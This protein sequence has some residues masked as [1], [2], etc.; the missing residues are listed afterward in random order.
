MDTDDSRVPY[1]FTIQMWRDG[2][3]KEV[4]VER[5]EL[6]ARESLGVV[7]YSGLYNKRFL[8]IRVLNRDG[9]KKRAIN[10]VDGFRQDILAL[11]LWDKRQQTEALFSINIGGGPNGRDGKSNLE[12][13]PPSNVWHKIER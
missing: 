9:N 12:S 5:R 3:V 10:V 8:V 7:E 6:M 1:I 11:K 4:K 13:R 2:R